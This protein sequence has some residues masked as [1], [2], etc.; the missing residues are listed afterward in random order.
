MLKDDRAAFDVF[1]KWREAPANAFGSKNNP[2]VISDRDKARY[3]LIHDELVEA[4]V[5]ARS[6]LKDPKTVEIK[7]MNY[8]PQYGARGHRPVDIWVSLCGTG[9][10]EFARMPQIYAIASDRG[11]ELGLAISISED[12]YHDLAVKIRNRTIVPLINQKLPLPESEQSVEIS[13]YLQREGGWHFNS[14]ARLSPGEDGFDEW[15]SLTD[16]IKAT[17][18]SGTKKGGGSICKLFSSEELEGLSLDEEFSRIAKVFHPILMACLPNQW[19]EQLVATHRAL[20][21]LND[22]VKFDPSNLKDAR[23]KVLRE[24]S[25]RRGQKKFR[26]ALLKAYDGA[27]VI[28]QSRV[29]P[30]LEA[31][32]IVPYLG[33]YTN[34]ISNGLLLRADLHTLFDLHLIKINPTSGIVEISPSLAATPYWKYHN[35]KISLPSRATDHPS[36]LALEQHYKAS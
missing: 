14:K 12:D 2:G 25:Q 24:I 5:A 31:A 28:S 27:C 6:S 3:T 17:K 23:D 11:L 8:S 4:A 20:D 10:E 21:E 32:H 36:Y 19:D 35:R 15:S 13:K 30:V 22:E 1:T 33:D 16:F 34:N 18:R 7:R 26:Q 29:E 9:S